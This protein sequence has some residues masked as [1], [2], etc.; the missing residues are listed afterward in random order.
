[1]TQP[2]PEDWL[3]IDLMIE[4]GWNTFFEASHADFIQAG[5]A[6]VIPVDY[7]SKDKDLI[8]VLS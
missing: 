2:I 3:G 6:R 4:N 5:G 1:M 7:R 8:A